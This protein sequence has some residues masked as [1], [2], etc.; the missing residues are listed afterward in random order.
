MKKSK[1]GKLSLKD[2][3]KGVFMTIGTTIVGLCGNSVMAGT[4]PA[5]PDFINMGKVGLLSG[6][7]YL[8]KKLLTNSNDELLKKEN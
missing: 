4:F 3:S 6:G 8:V 2:L 1:F 5:T 7:I